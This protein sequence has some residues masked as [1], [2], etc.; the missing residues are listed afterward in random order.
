MILASIFCIFVTHNKNYA[1][2]KQR[3][4]ERERERDKLELNK[5]VY[6]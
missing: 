3:E 1:F 4:R 5:R 2:E 6:I